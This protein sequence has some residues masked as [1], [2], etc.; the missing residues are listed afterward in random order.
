MKITREK[1]LEI[2]GN[3]SKQILTFTGLDHETIIV[4][5]LQ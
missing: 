4:S 3:N 1:L 5:L 2:L